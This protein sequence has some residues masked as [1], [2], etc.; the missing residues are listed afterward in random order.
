MR[1]AVVFHDFNLEGSLPASAS[2][3]ARGLVGEG[4]EVHCYRIRTRAG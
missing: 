2:I 3:L 1:V 4:V